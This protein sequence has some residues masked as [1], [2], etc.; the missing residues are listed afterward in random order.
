MRPTPPWKL[1]KVRPTRTSR[2]TV[3][4]DGKAV[5]NNQE[6]LAIGLANVGNSFFHGFA[7]TGAIARGALNY[8]SGVRTPLGGMF[9]GNRPQNS[10]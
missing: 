3:S 1:W 7:G 10:L 4:A 6:L 8:S 9:T 2:N 5:D